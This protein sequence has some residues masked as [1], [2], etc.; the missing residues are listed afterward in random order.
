MSE[1]MLAIWQNNET[2]QQKLLFQ[3]QRTKFTPCK[4]AH[5]CL[6]ISSALPSGNMPGNIR[7]ALSWRVGVH[8]L[9]AHLS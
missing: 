4:T 2:N 6:V 1:H 9:L 8:L 3:V 5:V 7:A